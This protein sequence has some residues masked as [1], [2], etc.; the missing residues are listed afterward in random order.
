MK[1]D[2]KKDLKKFKNIK[3][4]GKWTWTEGENYIWWEQNKNCTYRFR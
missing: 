4:G 1:N 3:I 2:L